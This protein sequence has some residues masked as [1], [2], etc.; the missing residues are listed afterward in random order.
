MNRWQVFAE[1]SNTNGWFW[2][3]DQEHR[4]VWMSDSVERLT[5]L[6][7]EWYY[8]KSGAEIR[9]EGVDDKAWNEHLGKL[10]NHEPFE[11]F[12]FDRAS[13]DG[14]KVLSTSGTPYWD[15]NGGFLGYRGVG[16]DLTSQ[17]QMA[18]QLELLG[19]IIENVDESI[20]IWDENDRL[21]NGNKMFW[22][23][24][25]GSKGSIYQG[26]S[27]EAYLRAVVPLGEFPDAI[28]REEDWIVERLALHRDP[29]G[30]IEM[31]RKDGRAIEVRERRLNNGYTIQISSEI[32]EKTRHLQEAIIARDRLADFAE[33]ASDWY[34]EQDADLRFTTI[35]QPNVKYTGQRDSA[36]I[37]KTRKE[38]SNIT[39]SDVE[40][41]KHDA[42]V[43]A[44]VPLVDFRMRS[45]N[46][47]SGTRELALFG[48][49]I[50][51]ADGDF[52]GYRGVGRDITAQTETIR[53]L[54]V[55]EHDLQESQTRLQDQVHLF[56]S[57]VASTR[58][59]FWHI[60][61]DGRT[62]NINPA[63]AEILG[64]RRDD[65]I[66]KTIYDFVNA[67]NRAIFEDQLAKRRHGATA[68]YE[69]ALSR[70]DG[71][72]VDCI[73]AASA[74]YDDNGE[75]IGSIGLWTDIRA[76]K[77]IQAELEDARELAE[78]ANAAKSDFLSAMSHELRTPLNAI[79]G[80]AQILEMEADAETTEDN[81]I[82]VTNILRS[83]RH[84]LDLINEILDL[85]RI[86]AK[87]ASMISESLPVEPVLNDCLTTVSGMA[88]QRNISIH[89][90]TSNDGWVQ[91]DPIRMKQ[92]LLNFLSNAIKYNKPGGTIT[93]SDEL[94]EGDFIRLKIRDTGHGIAP[95]HFDRI[96][97]P[98]ERLDHEKSEIE[99]TGIGLTITKRI[100]EAMGGAVGFSSVVGEG[101]VF[102]FD[103]PRA[104]QALRDAAELNGSPSNSLQDDQ[105]SEPSKTV[106][107]IED[108]PANQVLMKMILE[109][110]GFV[111]L[112]IAHTGEIG[113]HI[114]RVNHPDLIF[115][116]IN[117]PTANG[118]EVLHQLRMTESTRE[119]PV[120]GVSANSIIED[121]KRARDAG[122]DSYISKP[123]NIKEIH[124][125]VF[126]I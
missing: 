89:D 95:V 120:V 18:D 44:R 85:T 74:I 58:E 78:R 1:M 122:F 115:L 91:C 77:K 24:N 6:P 123:F 38:N 9:L 66:G 55:S 59:G 113:L 15:E 14:N 69:I 73:N 46:P 86:E 99:G 2:E 75:R 71:S 100:V 105:S 49:P 121:I 65:V 88:E 111:K 125:T 54:E 109:R 13:P 112:I 84:L 101:S 118:F 98:F 68:S 94:L 23:L 126:N 116:D 82:A 11:N 47:D 45:V 76:Q 5:G 52:K 103:L 67:E 108:N 29:G 70:P 39:A 27:Y 22:D 20:V 40:W 92:V 51:S 16:E 42:A 107:Y 79:I 19:G 61:N 114:A 87:Q 96:F 81:V 8:G 97:E 93:I 37:G 50:F 64:R 110:L 104:P 119:I 124:E 62:I 25:D 72:T 33:C 35:S 31:P 26:I 48:K 4:F 80:F 106:L 83:G 17:Y 36:F 90:H 10:S 117:L 102:W 63:M 53:S 21:V 28:G 56:E 41:A 12:V 32:T 3:T 34:W 57:L 43:A 7:P 30:P 60:D